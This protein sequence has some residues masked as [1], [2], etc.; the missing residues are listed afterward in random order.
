[1]ASINLAEL[2]KIYNETSVEIKYFI[3]HRLQNIYQYSPLQY[4]KNN[5]YKRTMSMDII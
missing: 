4:Y 1:M 3:R 2:T 5:L